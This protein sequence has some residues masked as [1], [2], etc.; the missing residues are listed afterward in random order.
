[1]NSMTAAR[2]LADAWVGEAEAGNSLGTERIY[3][4]ILNLK[5]ADWG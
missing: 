2:E 3:G 4:L 5:V 1:M